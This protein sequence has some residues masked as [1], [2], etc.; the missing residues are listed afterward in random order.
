MEA[1]ICF[2]DGSSGNFKICDGLQSAPIWA[3]LV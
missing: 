3:C 2:F 1:L